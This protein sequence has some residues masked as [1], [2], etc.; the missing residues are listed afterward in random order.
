MLCSHLFKTATYQRASLD[1]PLTPAHR[2]E[3]DHGE[4]E[5]YAASE[6][7]LGPWCM[8]SP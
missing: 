5:P 3:S 8:G 2:N 7:G 4:F 6:L 1:P